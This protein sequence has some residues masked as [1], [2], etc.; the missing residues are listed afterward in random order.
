[1][2]RSLIR[3]LYGSFRKKYLRPLRTS[4][5]GFTVTEV[6]VVFFIMTSI[7][8]VILPDYFAFGEKND[9]TNLAAEVALTIREAQVYGL[10]SREVDTTGGGPNPTTFDAPF[11]VYAEL[12]TPASLIFFSDKNNSGSYDASP[13][14]GSGSSNAECIKQFALK[15]GFSI[16][17][18]CT[19]WSDPTTRRCAAD[20]VFFAAVTFKRP[21][22]DG[23]IR[24]NDLNFSTLDP[25]AYSELRIRISSPSGASK[26]VNV[27]TTGQI[28]VSDS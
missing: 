3:S 24:R 14:C 28:S 22:P 23:N 1:M 17:D 12:L 8:A 15:D 6:L 16:T 20:G 5:R 18:I 2:R 7:L 27:T 4:T 21:N 25:I 26:Y 11:G 19:N 13:P 9:L 10:S